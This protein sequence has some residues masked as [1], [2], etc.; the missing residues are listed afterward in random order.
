MYLTT[1]L[2]VGFVTGLLAPR[3]MASVGHGLAVDILVGIAGAVLGG[4]LSGALGIRIP[5]FAGPSAILVAFIGATLL[6][7]SL[8]ELRRRRRLA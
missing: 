1:W 3:F 2:I 7:G 8:R 6:L 5:G 4:L